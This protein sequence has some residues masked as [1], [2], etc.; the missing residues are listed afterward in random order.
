LYVAVVICPLP[1]NDS[2]LISTHLVQSLSEQQLKVKKER[3]IKKE[4]LEIFNIMKN[5]ATNIKELNQS[6]NV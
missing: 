5:L 1:S 3:I 2:G 6:N 4:S